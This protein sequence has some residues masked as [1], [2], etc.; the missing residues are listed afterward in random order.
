MKDL[1]D[2]TGKVAIV[3]GGGFVPHIVREAKE[4]GVKTYITGII[5]PTKSDYD[6][7]YYPK[8]HKEIEKIGVN[9]IGCSH[10]LTEKWAMIY[11]LP[12]FEQFCDSEFIE[13]KEAL[14]RLE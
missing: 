12:Y 5:T 13:D 10:Y 9:L 4:K 3:T 14:K 6:K 11:S 2:L 7:K 1:F 8:A